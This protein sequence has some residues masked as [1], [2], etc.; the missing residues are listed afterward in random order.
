MIHTPLRGRGG[1]QRQILR[2]AIELQKAG[3][4]VEIFTNAMDKESYPEFFRSVKVNVIP[5]PLTGKLPA[6]LTPQIA[7]PIIRQ[8]PP[9]EAKR[10][11][12]LREWMRKIVGDQ[13]YTSEVPSMLS[14]ARKIPK[15]FDIINNHNFP[16][17]WA[18]FFAKKRL[19]APVVWMCNEPPFWFFA[20]EHK[21]G[22][23]KI[24]WPLF[25]LLDRVAV[26]YVDEIMVLSHVSAEYVRKAYDRTATIVRT[27]VDTEL[28]HNASGE[29]LRRKHSLGDSFVLLFVGGSLYARRSD[30]IRALYYL[31]KDFDNVRLILDV[32][33][34]RQML[35]KLAEKLGVRDKVLFLNSTSDQELAEVYAACDVFVYP[36]SA[37]PWGLV[38][39]EA[40]AA[41]KPVIVSKQA[42]ISEII[43][44]GVNGIV[45]DHPEPKEIA[46]QIEMLMNNPKLRKRIGENAYEYVKNS[47]SWEKY[48][49]NVENVFKETISHSKRGH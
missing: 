18:A 1:A 7:T 45:V 26:S 19:K 17:E 27:G 24:N 16:T 20:A 49:K 35:M 29:N 6:S 8:T 33:R 38:V 40:M 41:S 44:N 42:G 46:K 21:K 36:A 48:A 39:T 25:E 13:F 28:F 9:K 11:P 5:H 47:L 43:Q 30:I 2:L 3:N 10:S 15:G 23:R 22:L 14:L 34:Q 31:S 12:S 37:S 32:A 4:D